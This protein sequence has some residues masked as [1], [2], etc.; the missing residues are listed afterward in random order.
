MIADR[1]TPGAFT[2]QG[3]IKAGSLKF[4]TTL[5]A[6]APSYNKGENDYTLYYRETEDDPYD[7]LFNFTASTAGIYRITLNVV[8]K[9]VKFDKLED[10]EFSELWFVGD[11]TSWNFEPMV[12]DSKDANV[13]YFNSV[14]PVS[15]SFKIA[16]EPNFNTETV[17]FRP[18]VDGAGVGK[19]QNVLKYAGNPDDKWSLSAGT[20]KIKLNIKTLKID[21]VSFTPYSQLW[22]VGSASPAGWDIDNPTPL[23]V[24]SDVNIFTYSGPLVIDTSVGY[25]E[26]KFP[27]AKGDWGTDYFM[28]TNNWE[29]I[30]STRMIFV[31]GGSPDNKWKITESGN[32]TITINQ[33]KETISIVKN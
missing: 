6:L 14:L 11:A 32:Y 10:V 8:T 27:V 31:E 33:L 30:E 5:G 28:P 24:T 2:W 23:T 18:S 29:G 4:I 25:G 21:I 12:A 19:N 22:M 16:T 15:G 17:Y 20:Y 3:H 9:A 7:E 26:F 13:F 1:S